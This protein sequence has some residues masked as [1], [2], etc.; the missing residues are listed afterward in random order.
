MSG[1]SG[2]GGGGGEGGAGVDLKG[3]THTSTKYG[4]EH[5]FPDFP[6]IGTLNPKPPKP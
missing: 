5:H 6:C 2:R 1:P 3:F 4:G